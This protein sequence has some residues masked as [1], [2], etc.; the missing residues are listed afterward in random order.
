MCRSSGRASASGQFQDRARTRRQDASKIPGAVDIN[1]HQ[2]ID[3]PQFDVNMD[4]DQAIQLGLTANDIANSLLI[5]LSSSGQTARNY[6]VNPANG[7]NYLVA[8]QTPQNQVDSLNALNNT[9]IVHLGPGRPVAV[10]G[11]P[12]DVQARCRADQHQPLQ[13]P[14]HV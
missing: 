8:V 6:W 5:S 12:L 4:R 7:V 2:F 3:A 9:P 13:H 14:T 10:A 11:E 1:V